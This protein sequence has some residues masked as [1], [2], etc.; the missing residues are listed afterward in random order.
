[1]AQLSTLGRKSNS[2]A[3]LIMN[4]AA[5]LIFAIASLV[6]SLAALVSQTM[7]LW[8]A[9]TSN[10]KAATSQ[11]VVEKKRPSLFREPTVWVSLVVILYSEVSL[12]CMMF[13]A[14]HLATS[15]DVAIVGINVVNTLLSM[16]TIGVV[17][18]RVYAA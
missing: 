12:F 5:I 3:T 15:R 11:I 8:M 10:K 6:G 13:F 2:P 7:K 1:V 14:V 9:I 4:S 17:M 16:S 18:K